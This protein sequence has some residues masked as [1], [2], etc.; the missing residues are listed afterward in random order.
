M[1][2]FLLVV[3]VVVVTAGADH[4]RTGRATV[5]PGGGLPLRARAVASLEQKYRGGQI[6]MCTDLNQWIDGGPK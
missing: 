3:A 4:M 5:Q 2:S 6:E 1:R